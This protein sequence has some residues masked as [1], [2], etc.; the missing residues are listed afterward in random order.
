MQVGIDAAFAKRQGLSGLGPDFL[1]DLV[2]VHFTPGKQAQHQ[3]LRD[4]V[5]KTGVG[6]LHHGDNTLNHEACQHQTVMLRRAGPAAGGL[7]SLTIA[8]GGNERPTGGVTLGVGTRMVCTT[9]LTPAS[10]P[11]EGELFAVCLECRA[12]GLA[13]RSF[14]NQKSCAGLSS[15]WGEETGEG[16]RK[17]KS[18]DGAISRFRL[19]G[20][21]DA[22]DEIGGRNHF[23]IAPTMRTDGVVKS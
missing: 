23:L 17:T 18:K 21:A 1:H 22:M 16:G 14:A 5:Q 4:A 9:V 15:P 8:P 19:R 3:Q 11:E 12:T 7:Q 10:P 2:T 6:F 20:D 13:G